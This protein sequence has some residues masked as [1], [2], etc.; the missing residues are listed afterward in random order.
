MRQPA[1]RSK[2]DVEH[3]SEERGDGAGYDIKSF[4]MF[5]FGF[6]DFSLEGYEAQPSILAP[7]AVQHFEYAASSKLTRVALRIIF[8]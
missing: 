3:T 1:T 4:D 2:H 8:L 5:A 6:D 7:I